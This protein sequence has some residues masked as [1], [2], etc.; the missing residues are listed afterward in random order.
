MLG[1]TRTLNLARADASKTPMYAI[2]ILTHK[3]SVQ[4]LLSTEFLYLI[5]D[6]MYY[7]YTSDP[8]YFLCERIKLTLKVCKT[9]VLPLY[10]QRVNH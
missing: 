7:Y 9:L 8:Y 6:E 4:V 10:E 1:E 2:P 3:I 5:T